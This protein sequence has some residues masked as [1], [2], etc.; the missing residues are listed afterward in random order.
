VNEIVSSGRRQ[1]PRSSKEVRLPDDTDQVSQFS[2]F[3]ERYFDFVWRTV[4][5]LGAPPESTDD[6]VQDVFLVA[7]RRLADFEARSAPRTWLFAIALRVLSDYRRSQ[8]RRLRLLTQATTLPREPSP[9]PLERALN[10]ELQRALIAAIDSLPEE[11]RA[12]FVMTELEDMSAPEIA[13]ALQVKLNTVYSRL[14]AA[15]REMARMLTETAAY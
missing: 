10:T 9:N 13:S 12:V 3:Y 4:R 8:K 14:R 2:Q 1:L 7:Y 11:Q 6:A 15:R 5:F